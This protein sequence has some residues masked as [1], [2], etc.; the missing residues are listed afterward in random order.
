M[1]N[2]HR[3]LDCGR[4]QQFKLAFIFRYVRTCPLMSGAIMGEVINPATEL[5]IRRILSRL[6]RAENQ[7][8]QSP[9]L[10]WGDTRLRDTATA[11]ACSR[12]AELSFFRALAT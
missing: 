8:D 2:D 7:K 12:V 11:R 5:P 10:A 3:H 1:I 6:C 4:K 9:S